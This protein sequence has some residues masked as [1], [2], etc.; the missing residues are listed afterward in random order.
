MK[1]YEKVEAHVEERWVE[2]GE[3]CDLCRKPIVRDAFDETTITVDAKVGSV[4]PE[5]DRRAG[6]VADLCEEC[7]EGRALPT[8]RELGVRFHCYDTD[9]GREASDAERLKKGGA[10]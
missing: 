4:F 8:L 7:W 3:E 1:L 6:C 5:G 9:V 2:K 10:R